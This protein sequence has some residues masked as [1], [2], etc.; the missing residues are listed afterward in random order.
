MPIK[1]LLSE[2]YSENDILASA[3]NI[4]E[5]KFTQTPTFSSAA[6]TKSFLQF[7][8][9]ALE[10]ET[11]CIMHL[12]SQHHLIEFEELFRGTINA[13]AVYPREVVKSVLAHNASAVILVHNHPSGIPEPSESDKTLTRNL[14][15]ALAL[16]DVP[17]LDHVVVGKDCVSFAERGLL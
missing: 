12:N 5:E 15:A 17:V 13:A 10:H 2:T 6:D 11:F 4:L 16:I 1:R 3:A 14:K 8:M 7:K 9:A